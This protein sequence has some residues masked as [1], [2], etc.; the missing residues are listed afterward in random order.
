[1]TAKIVKHMGA[2]GKM[3]FARVCGEKW[4]NISQNIQSFVLQDEKVLEIYY[5][6]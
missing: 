6:A 3:V 4:G 1:M 2:D 5:T